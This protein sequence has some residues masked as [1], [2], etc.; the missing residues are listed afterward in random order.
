MAGTDNPNPAGAGRERPWHGEYQGIASPC[1]LQLIELES[2]ASVT[3]S[4]QPL[5]VPGLLQTEEYAR[6][7]LGQLHR[8][9]PG[10]RIESLVEVRMKRQELLDRAEAP[11]L[12][13]VLDEAAIRNFL[14]ARLASYKTPRRVL[15]VGDEDLSFTGSAKVKMGGLRELALKRLQAEAEAANA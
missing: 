11:L 8:G 3:R 9:A 10:E 7:V 15:F 1:L 12:F 2:A 13:F 5:L 14:L 4:F 6:V